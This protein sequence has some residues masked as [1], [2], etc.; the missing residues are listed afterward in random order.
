MPL[1]HLGRLWL[2]EE[3]IIHFV[4]LERGRFGLRLLPFRIIEIGLSSVIRVL[5]VLDKSMRGVQLWLICLTNWN[6]PDGGSGQ[7]TAYG[8]LEVANAL[9]DV[10]GFALEFGTGGK[11][12]S[13]GGGGAAPE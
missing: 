9:D 6:E 3:Q 4:A 5:R 7:L 10:G 13:E 2:L 12:G 8:L 11:D 1:V